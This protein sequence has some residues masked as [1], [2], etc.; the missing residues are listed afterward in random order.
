MDTRGYE[1]MDELSRR[2]AVKLH[3]EDL[4]AIDARRISVF[5]DSAGR[6]PYVDS[7]RAQLESLSRTYPPPMRV[8]STTGSPFIFGHPSQLG[9]DADPSYFTGA[10][11]GRSTPFQLPSFITT[12]GGSWHMDTRAT[13]SA[14]PQWELTRLQPARQQPELIGPLHS[15]SQTQRPLGLLQQ[16]QLQVAPSA[17]RTGIVRSVGVSP[18]LSGPR[19]APTK[20]CNICCN[21]FPANNFATLP[22]SDEYCHECLRNLCKTAL[23]NEASFPPRCCN[24]EIPLD[25][26][27]HHLSAEMYNDLQD[28]K[29]EYGT[30]NRTYCHDPSC[31]AFIPRDCNRPNNLGK[32]PKC[33]SMT[34]LKC[35][36]E[37][38]LF[39]SCQRNEGDLKALRFAEEKGWKRC[40]RC[41]MVLERD[42][43]CIHMSKYKLDI[44]TF[45]LALL[46]LTKRT[47]SMHVWCR[48]LLHLW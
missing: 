15:L 23:Q 18:L 14:M 42:M 48:I 35:K 27:R 10:R 2:L 12:G 24:R 26:I 41:G 11:Q 39:G 34:C 25:T 13:Q 6:D 37:Q 7:Y 1:D 32:C 16:T 17:Y 43:G 29:L 22:C 40:Y 8:G 3:L 20:L 45:C 19:G 31:N 47:Y 44:F 46:M 33:G 28:K 30:S 5:G 38:H 21:E 4:D 9:V 36:G